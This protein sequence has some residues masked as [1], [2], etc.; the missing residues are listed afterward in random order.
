MSKTVGT[1]QITIT[2]LTDGELV[3]ELSSNLANTQN[4]NTSSVLTPDWSKTNLIITPHLTFN[5]EE[6]PLNTQ[7]LSIVFTKREL[8]GE[9]ENI[10]NI[11]EIFNE[12]TKKLTIKRNMLLDSQIITYFCK[13]TY[14][15]NDKTF[16]SNSLITFNLVKDGIN[17]ANGYSIVMSNENHTF[18]GDTDHALEDSTTTEINVYKGTELQNI[19]ITEINNTEVTSTQRTNT[20][21]T[22]LDYQIST[23]NE[24]TNPSITFYTDNSMTTS[25]GKITIKIQVGQMELTKNFSFS[26]AFKGQNG[27]EAAQVKITSKA[28]IFQSSDNGLTFLPEE[29]VLTPVFTNSTFGA[30]FYSTDESG[31]GQITATSPSANNDRFYIDNQTK[32]LIIPSKATNFKNTNA[33]AF[34]CIT[35]QG[36]YDLIT[37]SQIYD[38]RN[39][40]IGGTNLLKFTA[41]DSLEGVS[42][43]G[44]YAQISID[45]SNNYNNNN[46]LKIITTTGSTYANKDLY[47]SCWGAQTENESLV[48]SFYIKGTQSNGWVYYEGGS[49]TNNDR[50]IN[51]FQVTSNWTKVKISLGKVTNGGA[52][53]GTRIVLGFSNAGTFYINSMKLEEG[54]IDTSWSA[55]PQDL[56]SDFNILKQDLEN[57]ID[58]KIETYDQ[59]EDPSLQ[60]QQADYSKHIGDLW[61][62]KTDKITYR[63]DGE[64][65]TSNDEL[66]QSA[67][68][69]AKQKAKI[70]TAQPIP[71]YSIGDMWID[72]GFNVYYCTN[73]KTEGMAFNIGDWG[74]A[75]TG[76]SNYDIKDNL[77]RIRT[78]PQEDWSSITD[79]NI[80][81]NAEKISSVVTSTNM[82]Y[83]ANVNSFQ[84]QVTNG[85]TTTSETMLGFGYYLKD[86]DYDPANP[87]EIDVTLSFYIY[88]GN[89]SSAQIYVT[90]PNLFSYNPF[91]IE[92]IPS[93]LTMGWTRYVAHIKLPTHT[94]LDSKIRWDTGVSSFI[95]INFNRPGRYFITMPKLEKGTTASSWISNITNDML[96]YNTDLTID[97]KKVQVSFNNISQNIQLTE[98]ISK[99]GINALASFVI[100]DDDI[101]L[102]SLNTEGLTINDETGDPL[103]TLDVNGLILNPNSNL[104]LNKI[105][106]TRQGLRSYSNDNTLD[107]EF[108]GRGM[109]IYREGYFLGD[110]IG[111]VQEGSTDYGIRMGLSYDD[112]NINRE[113]I[114]FTAQ[115]NANDSYHYKLWYTRG[116]NEKTR[117]FSDVSGEHAGSSVL[118]CMANGFKTNGGLDWDGDRFYFQNTGRY[119][120]WYN[121]FY[122]GPRRFANRFDFYST[123]SKSDTFNFSYGTGAEDSRTSYATFG[124]DADNKYPY[125]DLLGTWLTL[126]ATN[127][128]IQNGNAITCHR[129]LNMQG[130]SIINSVIKNNFKLDSSTYNNGSYSGSDFIYTNINAASGNRIRYMYLDPATKALVV[131]TQDGVSHFFGV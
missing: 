74:F 21:I 48:L 23:I 69:I 59:I 114:G 110:V 112:S 51:T 56:I 57:Q 113:Y 39:L 54:T 50:D 130:N 91:Q 73:S 19:K 16:S 36:V 45:K 46:S 89:T 2:D 122:I 90:L 75:A 99:D 107:I 93:G 35:N 3:L 83:R 118:F 12:S 124:Y 82:I 67:E 18:I 14:T 125:I 5:N 47:Q 34:Q 6:L 25:S 84:I 104:G 8:S 101:V 20:G 11:D 111:S 31:W 61:Y 105:T 33:I 4:L 60:W 62:N 44:D 80:S 106:L 41:Y 10:D 24:S 66:A 42:V 15:I 72:V 52:A 96:N 109:S 38:S 37:I 27:E 76:D 126:G 17:G 131:I 29:I 94:R 13:A 53:G 58:G 127:I 65:W 55:A 9:I 28:Q 120:N 117:V 87:E 68:N 115:D 30:W 1:G 26:I 7:N 100:K 22:G 32:N 71:P 102:L 92:T 88:N 86:L 85:Y 77:L 97:S 40:S 116:R 78:N 95:Y 103:M 119:M 64:N 63:W 49:T 43:R 98:L 70:F 128:N 108:N 81:F 121:R 79:S 123:T 129:E